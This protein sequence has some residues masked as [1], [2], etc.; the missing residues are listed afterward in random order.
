MPKLQNKV[1][2]NLF[3]P[4]VSGVHYTL[5]FRRKANTFLVNDI[6][7][8]SETYYIN[9]ITLK[10]VLWKG[11]YFSGH[12]QSAMK[13][14]LKALF[15]DVL[16]WVMLNEWWRSGHMSMIFWQDVKQSLE[17]INHPNLVT[18]N[19]ILFYPYFLLSHV[20]WSYRSVCVFVWEGEARGYFS[21]VK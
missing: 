1:T 11:R 12:N 2:V 8:S 7:Y 18:F 3:Y 21:Q 9:I 16:I 14:I 17:T 5:Y 4:G 19:I 13:L 20:I 6:C 15:K 10:R